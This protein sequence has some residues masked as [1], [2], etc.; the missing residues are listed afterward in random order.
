[1]KVKII[2][3]QH[4]TYNIHVE[5]PP[6]TKYDQLQYTVAMYFACFHDSCLKKCNLKYY[7]GC[8]Q[9]HMFTPHP[10]DARYNAF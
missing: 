8:V 6:S 4:K 7:P 1:M 10:L 9:T 2:L 3:S 5:T